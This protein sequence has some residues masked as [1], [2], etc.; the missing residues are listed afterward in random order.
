MSERCDKRRAAGRALAGAGAAALLACGG[1]R[2]YDQQVSEIRD[3]YRAGC[4]EQAAGLASQRLASNRQGRDELIWSLEAATLSRCAGRAQESESQYARADELYERHQQEAKIK[5]GSEGLALITN[6]AKLPYTGR[7]YDGIMVS[8]Y[9]ALA[10][11]QRGDRESARVYLNRTYQRQ[12]SAVAEH[13]AKIEKESE[14][15][16]KDADLSRTLSD[17]KLGA[18]C[19]GLNTQVEGLAAYADYVNPFA[20]Y[21]DGLYH[22]NAGLDQSD[23]ERA[24]KCFERALAFAPDNPYVKADY[25]LASRSSRPGLGEPACYV[26]FETGAGPSRDAMR[27]DV[28]IIVSRVSYVGISFPRLV[29]HGGF[30]GALTVEA[31]GQSAATARVASMD[32]IVAH[33]YKNEL[34]SIITRSVASAVAKAAAAYAIN[35]QAEKDGGEAAKWAA[36]VATAG[37]QL[38]MNVADTRTWN[39]LPKEFQV[40]KVAIPADRKIALTVPGSGWRQ[41]LT[42]P[43]GRSV[44]VWAKTVDQPQQMAITQFALK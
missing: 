28:P 24:R 41:E 32:A 29:L 25:E 43:E 18:A 6:P 2:T 39:T 20:V 3:C 42:L 21:L 4:Y 19:A 5:V 9:Q 37:Y 8:V 38:V 44:V 15:V 30:V 1:C 16:K 40:C 12:Q 26:L 34:P 11:L 27:I 36:R 10:A 14:Q 35:R 31:G 33:D 13:A 7:A 22:W 23:V 17:E